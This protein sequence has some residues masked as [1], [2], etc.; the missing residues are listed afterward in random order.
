MLSTGISTRYR[1]KSAITNSATQSVQPNHTTIKTI[2]LQETSHPPKSLQAASIIDTQVQV[3]KQEHRARA[4]LEALWSNWAH[5]MWWQWRVMLVA[6][7]I[8][9]LSRMRHSIIK[10]MGATSLIQMV[11]W[12]CKKFTIL[13]ANI[14]APSSLAI[15]ASLIRKEQLQIF[16]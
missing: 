13:V 1:C 11:R 15:T 14:M 16:A 4:L 9:C 5:Q 6:K 12:T 8:C 10:V 2:E 7:G 3:I